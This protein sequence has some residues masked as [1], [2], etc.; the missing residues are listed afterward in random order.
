[1]LMKSLHV[2]AV[3]TSHYP[4]DPYL[5]DL[6]DRYG[7]WVDDEVDIETHAHETC[8]SNCLA[9]RPEW[10]AAFADRFQAMVARDKNH[11][12]VI[13]WDTGNEAGLGTAHYAM[14]D[15]ARRQ[16]ADPAAVPPVQHQPRRRRAVRRCGRSAL[17]DAGPAGGAGPDQPRSRS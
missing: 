12:S 4:S 17:P 8:P 1:M 5:Y 11:P 16:R 15:W 7:L 14:A 9:S 2:N 10:Q 13:F 3:R 6:A